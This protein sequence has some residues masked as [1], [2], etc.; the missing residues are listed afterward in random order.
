MALK[1]PFK[2]LTEG[3]YTQKSMSAIVD[4]HMAAL[5]A[6]KR[7]KAGRVPRVHPL[8]TEMSNRSC[9]ALLQIA[10]KKSL[11]VALGNS[12]R[13]DEVIARLEKIEVTTKHDVALYSDTVTV[14]LWFKLADEGYFVLHRPSTI[15]PSDSVDMNS[16]MESYV[17]F[18]TDDVLRLL[19]VMS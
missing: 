19:A 17:D 3:P 6:E 11:R 8:A 14:D 5:E 12:E 18:T 15:G 16:L 1:N 4:E 7:T 10:A 9:V 13:A 2:G